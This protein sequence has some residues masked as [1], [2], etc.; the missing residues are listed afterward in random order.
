MTHVFITF[1]QGVVIVEFIG[2][3]WANGPG[4]LT[5]PKMVKITGGIFSSKTKYVYLA[6]LTNKLAI[7]GE[8]F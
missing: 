3:G 4:S 5:R 7:G 2:P 6:L 1:S 8:N